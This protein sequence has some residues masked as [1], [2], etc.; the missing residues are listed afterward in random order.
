MHYSE[1]K[2]GSQHEICHR[3]GPSE[4]RNKYHKLSAT[5]PYSRDFYEYCSPEVVREKVTS[6]K[7]CHGSLDLNDDISQLISTQSSACVAQG[8]H[9]CMLMRCREKILLWALKPK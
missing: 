4:P 7:S 3:R 9:K 8:W 2:P 1:F 6:I 5:E